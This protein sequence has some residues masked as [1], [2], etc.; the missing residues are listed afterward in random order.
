MIEIDVLDYIDGK[1]EEV[2][3]SRNDNVVMMGEILNGM[4]P[5]SLHWEDSEWVRAWLDGDEVRADMELLLSN[6]RDRDGE[7]NQS[8]KLKRALEFATPVNKE[9]ATSSTRKVTLPFDTHVKKVSSKGR[10]VVDKVPSGNTIAMQ[11]ID[12]RDVFSRDYRYARKL[13]LNQ[14]TLGAH[15][16]LTNANTDNIVDAL[17]YL[18]KSTTPQTTMPPTDVSTIHRVNIS[19]ENEFTDVLTSVPTSDDA[20][21][22]QT[23]LHISKIS[24]LYDV[25]QLQGKQSDNARAIMD[26]MR[27]ARPRSI[28]YAKAMAV[29]ANNKLAHSRLLFVCRKQY[30]NLFNPNSKECLFKKLE[31]F[32]VDKLPPEIRQSVEMLARSVVETENAR[33]NSTCEHSMLINAFDTANY[34]NDKI[35]KWKQLDK[36]V[37]MKAGEEFA[38]CKLCNA[39]LM[40]KHVVE[41]WS[42]LSS[43]K[44]SNMDASV[45]SSRILGKYMFG[46][47]ASAKKL[48][49]TGRYS[50]RICGEDLGSAYELDMSSRG[51]PDANF[52]DVNKLV[53]EVIARRGEVKHNSVITKKYI[54]KM[55]ETIIEPHI[56]H[57]MQMAEAFSKGSSMADVVD[58]YTV[59]FIFAS[60]VATWNANVGFSFSQ[61]KHVVAKN[62]LRSKFVNAFNI[63]VRNY[64]A[65]IIVDH[66]RAKELMV[67]A[68]TTVN[69]EIVEWLTG[70]KEAI[71]MT[72]PQ[73]NVVDDY[74]VLSKL[75]QASIH[76][77]L[78]LLQTLS[79]KK[80]G[81]STPPSK[82]KYIVHIDAPH[83]DNI[84]SKFVTDSFT[85][86]KTFIDGKLY[87]TPVLQRDAMW[88]QYSAAVN[89][90]KKTEAE[91]VNATAKANAYAFSQARRSN[92][93][94]Y[95]NR[96][97]NMNPY[98]CIS[99]NSRHVFNVYVF[100]NK[101]DGNV[102]DIPK[103]KINEDVI[104][105]FTFVDHKCSAC[106]HT[107][108]ELR[109]VE[110]DRKAVD[111]N[112]AA[113]LEA[114]GFYRMF[115]SLCPAGDPKDATKAFHKFERDAKTLKHSCSQCGM[116][117]DEWLHKD[118]TW[119]VKY[120]DLY[121]KNQAIESQRMQ[122]AVEP[123][124]TKKSI[125]TTNEKSVHTFEDIRQLVKEFS[126]AF[127]VSPYLVFNLGNSEAVDEEELKANRQEGS[128]KVRRLKLI[129]HARLVN[130]LMS[131]ARNGNLEM[132]SES[133]QQR[134]TEM[135][136][137]MSPMSSSDRNNL[138]ST[139][140]EFEGK[141]TEDI[142]FNVLT[143]LLSLRKQAPTLADWIFKQLTN[144][145]ILYTSFNYAELKKV[146]N[147]HADYD[148]AD[149]IPDVEED[150]MF[151]DW[152]LSMNNMS[153][154]VE[155][156]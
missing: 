132:M 71:T 125:V 108:E 145:D 115:E 49:S 96:G 31:D 126:D 144:V 155:V 130:V 72:T 120:A 151:N 97:R 136:S 5:T 11:T 76:P 147:T 28:E 45:V 104:N 9:S 36:V 23:A 101:K 98:I 50:C 35:A 27:D 37:D 84:Y 91:L 140:V 14:F 59:I 51:H 107:K 117:W 114:D 124:K 56:A 111:A 38:S 150:D 16:R 7:L 109:Q 119:Y 121:R 118:K 139:A 70:A 65:R 135:V 64:G 128:V 112:W 77:A 18:I 2:T 8:M 46:A 142:M 110:L 62:T 137:L 100:K 42:A 54:T 32:S 143:F 123:H 74:I 26:S 12:T 85:T 122:K 68:Y 19:V 146:F 15:V 20:I 113:S 134:D 82:R 69:E 86:W 22:M 75:T 103:K 149:D 52:S 13:Y 47:R 40:C 95:Y 67:K 79:G 33:V 88:K 34:D 66:E 153:D 41:L 152:D 73:E 80:G 25:I 55:V 94:Y 1:P 116:T 24:E 99:T 92:A 154:D 131:K 29:L 148:V 141:S 129:E 106:K 4:K 3:T 43:T 58:M 102:V 60:L 133:K 93:R 21:S 44:K 87:T 138:P 30:P 10:V 78:P 81:K 83:S 17:R 61:D 48:T 105:K 53:Y 57:V 127:S 89:S 90:L 63:L 6:A 39:R 156:D